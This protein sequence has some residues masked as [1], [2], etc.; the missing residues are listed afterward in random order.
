[1]AAHVAFEKVLQSLSLVVDK[2]EK[3][4]EGQQHKLR[5]PIVLVRGL[6]RSSA[7]WL[8]F[9][10]E[11]AKF[12]CVYTLD[13]PGTGKSRSRLGRGSIPA[14]GQDVAAALKEE[15]LLPCHLIGIS[16]GGM[17]TAEATRI[18]ERSQ[19]KRNLE[20]SKVASLTM[21][22]SS[23]GFTGEERIKGEALLKLLWSLRKGRP[24]HKEIAEYLVSPAFLKEHPGLVET[25]DN[26]YAREGFRT[27]AVVRQLLAAAF[28][29]GEETLKEVQCPAFFLVSK[30]DGLV[31]WR[32]TPRLWEQVAGSQMVVVEGTGHDIPTER[33]PEVARIL[34][35]FLQDAERQLE[36]EK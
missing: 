10:A 35:P 1:L 36:Q 2:D 24:K 18:L 16:L 4:I 15:G 27:I 25:W 28:F 29:H 9:P 8:D 23:A 7:F 3:Q 21:I 31:S 17:V 32:N 19:K 13:L 34:R 6:G 30:N 20:A 11:L 12:A 26:I 14:L 22:G 5:Y 33:G